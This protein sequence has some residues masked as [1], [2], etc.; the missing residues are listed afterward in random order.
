MIFPNNYVVSLDGGLQGMPGSAR[1]R[2]RKG[3]GPVEPVDQIDKDVEKVFMPTLAGAALG[4]IRS[5]GPGTFT[6]AGAG[7]AFGLLHVLVTRGDEIRLTPGTTME[8]VLR[9]PLTLEAGRIP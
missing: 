4:S 7:A 3:Q 8:M 1:L 6:G 2:A 5:L 9:G